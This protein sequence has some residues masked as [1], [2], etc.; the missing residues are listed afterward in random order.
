MIRPEVQVMIVKLWLAL[1]CRA[2]DLR[3]DDSSDIH[4]P[5]A[6]LLAPGDFA[7]GKI[8]DVRY[9]TTQLWKLHLTCLT[10]CSALFLGAAR[11]RKIQLSS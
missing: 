2:F 4:S 10:G 3:A 5:S 6:S 7:L 9:N 8:L 11:E 1:A